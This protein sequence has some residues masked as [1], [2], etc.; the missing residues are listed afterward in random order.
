MANKV[1][2]NKNNKGSGGGWHKDSFTSQYKTILYLN[3]AKF[4]NGAF[5]L[6]L[7]SH[8]LMS[9]LKISKKFN[10]NIFKTRFSNEEINLLTFK[11]NKIKTLY[12]KAGTLIIV[13]TSM[14]HRGRPLKKG[15]R[16]AITNYYY[17]YYNFK[18]YKNKFKPMIKYNY[19]NK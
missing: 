11:D 19:L 4:D 2:Y 18:K 16:Y 1:K 5:E 6:I 17:P 8:K 10:L 9:C 14:I 12:G 7:D 3:D 13:D 15:F